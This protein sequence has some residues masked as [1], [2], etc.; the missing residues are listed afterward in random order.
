MPVTFPGWNVDF[1]PPEGWTDEQCETVPGMK[2]LE[3][4]IPCNILAL[5]PNLEDL[6]AL[7]KTNI[8]FYKVCAHT[9]TPFCFF[10]NNIQLFTMFHEIGVDIENI[11][12]CVFKV[13]VAENALKE[14]NNGYH[15]MYKAYGPSII[16]F[17]TYTLNEKGE[18]NF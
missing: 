5:K 6:N 7:N 8:F 16:P 9:P 14:I 4:G 11:P 13:L 12:F 15:V 18:G 2:C 10:V 17:C 3:N 1:S